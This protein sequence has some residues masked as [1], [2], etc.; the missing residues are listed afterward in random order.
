MTDTRR[1]QP[2]GKLLA[3]WWNAYNAR[4]ENRM[5]KYRKKP[6]IVEAVQWT[7]DNLAE[8]AALLQLDEVDIAGER[9]RRTGDRDALLFVIRDEPRSLVMRTV[10]GE[11]AAARVDDWVIREPVPGRGYP[12]KPDIFAETYEPVTEDGAA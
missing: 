2:L 7:G 9:A 8:V 5:R 4:Q 10:H 3:P 6:V 11:Q 12:C 1:P